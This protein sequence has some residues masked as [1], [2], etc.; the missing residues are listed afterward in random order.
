MARL[1]LCLVCLRGSIVEGAG[2]E[3]TTEVLCKKV[4]RLVKSQQEDVSKTVEIMN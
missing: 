3:A 4:A 2:G 1:P